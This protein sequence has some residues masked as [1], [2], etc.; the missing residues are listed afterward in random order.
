[1]SYIWGVECTLAQDGTGGPPHLEVL[2]QNGRPVIIV[3]RRREEG[4]D[5]RVHRLRTPPYAC[6]LVR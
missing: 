5:Q 6:R 4:R 2:V 3:E 1:M